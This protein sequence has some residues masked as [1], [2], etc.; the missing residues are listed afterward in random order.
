MTCRS[1]CDIEIANTDR[2][3]YPFSADVYVYLESCSDSNVHG[4]FVQL[5]IE[6]NAAAIY[7]TSC[8]CTARYTLCAYESSQ[9]SSV[10]DAG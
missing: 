8:G 10:K 2:M 6:F 7:L 3:S 4:D 9:E 1:A 5:N